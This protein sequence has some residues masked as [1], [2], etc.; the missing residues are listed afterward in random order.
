MQVK[1]IANLFAL[2]NYFVRA[3]RP[4][5]VMDIVEEF[6]W[7]RSSA[8]NVVSTLVEE[9]FLYQPV[10]RGSYHPTSRWMELARGLSEAQP[11]PPSVHQLLVDLMEKTG[12]TVIL[13]AIE[14]TT[15]V[16]LDVVETSNAIRYSAKVGQ[17]LPL[18]VTA[19]GRA[20]LAQY[21]EVER[22]AILR[23]IKYQRYQD[24][25]FM[26]AEAVEAAV[27][28]GL[29]RGWHVNIAKFASGVAGIAI[30]FAF[31]GRRLAIVIGAPVARVE[32]RVDALGKLL[33]DCVRR[34]LK[35]DMDSSKSAN[36]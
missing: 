18:H 21:S 16:F 15:T 6:G 22:D 13:C 10:P 36:T 5:S 1:Q 29:R 24:A 25:D 2:M 19:A 34:L 27:Q 7:P 32:D 3:R 33:R 31:R 4:L 20:L 11:L 26:S 17:R 35:D 28:E 9:G 12:E 8:F 30:P 23:A 14:G